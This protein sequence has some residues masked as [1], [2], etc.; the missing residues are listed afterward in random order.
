LHFITLVFSLLNS[1]KH[2]MT[3]FWKD[4]RW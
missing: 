1:V 2:I 4:D 3:L